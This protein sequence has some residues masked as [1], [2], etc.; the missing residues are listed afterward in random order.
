MNYRKIDSTAVGPALTDPGAC[1][2]CGLP[3]PA[4]LDLTVRIDGENRAM[5][6]H[7]CQ[8]VAEAIIDA[9]HENFYRVRTQAAPSARDI[10]PGFLQEAR[11]YDLPE[12]QNQFVHA[13]DGDLREASL[14]LDGITCA[15]CVWLNERYIGALPG[16]VEV[17][18]NYATQRALVRW[19][20]SRIRLGEIL[21]AIRKIGYRALPYNP[22]QQQELQRR[23]RRQQQRRLAVAGL[24]GMQVMMLSISLYGGAWSGMERGFEQFFRW[25]SLGL[26]LPVLLYS[27]PPFFQAAWRDLKRLRVAMDLPVSLAIGI[28][29]ASSVVTTVNGH[30][31]IYFDSVVMF[32]FFLSASR[33]FE[34]MARQRSAA[35]IEKLVQSLPLTTT[36]V[37]S[38]GFSEE[39]VAA[40]ALAIGDRVLIRPGETV[41]ADGE[42]LSGYSSVDESMLTGESLALARRPGERLL[43]GSINVTNPLQMRVTAVGADTVMAEIQRSIERAQ[44][45]KPP[46]AR[47]VD[48][49]AAY[50]I[51]AVLLIVICVA[52]FWWLYDA[53]RWFEIALAVLIVSCPC[54][55]SLATPAAMSAALGRMHSAGLLVKQGS[56]LEKM[57]QVTHVVI[58][59]TGTLTHGKPILQ[60][61][62]CNPGFSRDHCLRLAAT[63]EKHSEHPL[64]RALLRETGAVKSEDADQI[65]NTA[66]G[67]ISAIVDNRQ[68][69]IGSNEFILASTG[70]AIPRDWQDSLAGDALTAVV[71]ARRD[72]ILAMFNFADTLREDA[73]ALVESLQQMNKSIV[74][75]TGDRDAAAR[76]VAERTGIGEYRAQMSPQDKMQAVQTLQR[77]GACVLMVGDGVNDAPV[78]ANADVSIA[79]GGASALARTNADIVLLTNS[80]RS[81]VLAFDMSSRTRNIIRQNMIWALMYNFGAIPAAAAGLVAP[82]LAALGMS[83]SSLIV[84]LNALRLLR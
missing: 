51:G 52:S 14:M 32:I 7:G 73:A 35:S 49:V 1:Y 77:R 53:G 33:Y 21:Q 10:L 71:L 22:G 41:P 68:Y 28:A 79:M 29:F 6:C 57:N 13:L 3:V 23:Q 84:V 75:M 40:A 31:E 42:I 72:C 81:V 83:L 50:F 30:G 66:G 69:F 8:A 76:D 17:H 80:L 16:V 63:L 74:L 12:I 20:G 18:V 48:R 24:F 47:R 61:V 62:Y 46:S 43:G 34:N 56:A 9:G 15:A 11:V 36:R 44:T 59:K 25:L 39:A 64:A 27:A 55:L 67:G 58:D 26:T 70:L 82:W 5:C 65:V 60:Q 19:D 38:D 37:N 4:G 45:D 78:L 54:A 2:H